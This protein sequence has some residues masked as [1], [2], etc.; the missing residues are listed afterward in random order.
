MRLRDVNLSE[1]PMQRE[2]V[3]NIIFTALILIIFLDPFFHNSL[4]AAVGLGN[5]NK[6][7]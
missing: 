1:A 6:F 3:L 2:Q 5:C 7:E 4:I